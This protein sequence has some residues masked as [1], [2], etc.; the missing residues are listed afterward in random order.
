MSFLIGADGRVLNASVTKSS[1][2]RDLD[3]AA[4]AALSKC[5][6]KPGTLDG[7]PVESSTAVQYVW[8]LD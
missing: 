7:K 6:F 3:K 2:F 4:I 8:K 5:V 1:G